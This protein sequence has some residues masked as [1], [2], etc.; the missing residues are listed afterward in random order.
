MGELIQ[1]NFQSY[2]SLTAFT[3]VWILLVLKG[4][5]KITKT[6]DNQ[7]YRGLVRI[8]SGCVLIGLWAFCIVYL[9]LY[10]IFL[11]HWE[12]N[13]N[14]FEERIGIIDTIDQTRND[15][16]HIVIDDT[17]YTMVYSTESFDSYDLRKGDTVKFRYG[18][19]S[20]FIFDIAQSDTDH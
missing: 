2:I 6:L 20:K 11:A 8:G 16:V 17:K 13:N 10:P 5:F 12:Y 14:L 19:Q 15:R 1:T 4:I 7:R 9:F 18:R 3:A